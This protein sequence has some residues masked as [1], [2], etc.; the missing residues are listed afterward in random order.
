MW[1]F[2]LC[3][4]VPT[5]EDR[6]YWPLMCLRRTESIGSLETASV[7]GCEC[8]DSFARIG[9]LGWRDGS[10]IKSTDYS[11]KGSEFNF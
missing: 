2:S 5:K 1:E 11:P 3:M 7:D 10:A 8:W 6:G 4:H 9:L